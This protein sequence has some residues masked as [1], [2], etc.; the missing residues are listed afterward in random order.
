MSAP[1]LNER[2]L[3]LAIHLAP[4]M[5][6]ELFEVFAEI[7]EV[8]TK[9]PVVLLYESRFGRPV[10]KDITDI[11]IL[12]AADDWNDG[13]LLP[14]S[15]VFEHHLNKNNSPH[16]FVDILVANDRAPHVE[17]NGNS[18]LDVLQMV[19]NKQAE[20]GVLEAPVIRCQKLAVIGAE[21][22]H[23][24]ASLGPLPPYR[25][26]IN[27]AQVNTLAKELATYLLNINQNKEWMDRLSTFGI[28][29]FA[30]NST[31]FYNQDEKSI[32]TS[33]PYY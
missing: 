7:I 27:K 23:I 11:A 16:V 29:G 31:D 25:I 3:V 24:L 33:V 28:V 21:F 9:K 10:A 15:F 26:M 32:P 18:Q 17:V 20:V 4:S 30:E 22:L 14:V 19:A 1:N 6:I 2:P 8:I 13:V 12:P 5:P